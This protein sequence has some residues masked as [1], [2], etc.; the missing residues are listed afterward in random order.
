MIDILQIEFNSRKFYFQKIPS[1]RVQ[2]V[3]ENTV[4][5]QNDCMYGYGQDIINVW[6]PLIDTNQFN[7]LH[8]AS[9]EDSISL[10]D[11]FEN[12]KNFFKC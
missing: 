5:Y 11:T 8:L 10:L 4:N 7:S 12:E 9:S 6:I 2:R 3:N 1:F